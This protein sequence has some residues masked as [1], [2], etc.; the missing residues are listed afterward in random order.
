MTDSVAASLHK[1][2]EKWFSHLP[3]AAQENLQVQQW[4]QQKYN[5]FNTYTEK[6]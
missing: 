6:N 5:K 4:Q 1:K 2:I 3:Q